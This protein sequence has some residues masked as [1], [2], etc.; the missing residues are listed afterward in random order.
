VSKKLA[1]TLSKNTA[2]LAAM[3]A[4]MV[5]KSAAAIVDVQESEHQRAKQ[6]DTRSRRED[7]DPYQSSPNGPDAGGGQHAP[8]LET[9]QKKEGKTSPGEPTC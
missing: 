9:W 8:S 3:Q 7:L 6:R 5:Q 2:R 1:A 4:V